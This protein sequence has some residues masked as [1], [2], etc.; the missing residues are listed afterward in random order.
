MSPERSVVAC[1][2]D[3]GDSG[4]IQQPSQ[5]SLVK[6]SNSCGDH[7]SEVAAVA[8]SCMCPETST[9]SDPVE[10]AEPDNPSPT[11]PA[12]PMKILVEEAIKRVRNGY[13]TRGQSSASGTSSRRR[14]I[15]TASSASPSCWALHQP[16]NWQVTNPRMLHQQRLG[17]DWA[18]ARSTLLHQPGGPPLHLSWLLWVL[19]LPPRQ[20]L[21]TVSFFLLHLVGTNGR[22]G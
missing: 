11:I 20:H 15:S 14:V 6:R 17:T 16:Q 2:T 9:S 5:A 13:R 21:D 22:T 18:S 12:K 10:R 1:R 4:T 8:L 7:S 3:P 19:S